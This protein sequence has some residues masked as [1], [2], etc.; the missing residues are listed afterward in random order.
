MKKGPFRDGGGLFFAQNSVVIWYMGNM[1]D[2][3]KAYDAPKRY[4]QTHPRDMQAIGDLFEAIRYEKD[5]AECKLYLAGLN[6][7]LV[8]DDWDVNNKKKIHN[9]IRRANLFLAPRWFHNFMLYTEWVREPEKRFYQPRM[10]ALRPVVEGLQALHDGTYTLLCL[11]LPP[12]VGKSTLAEFFLTFEGGNYPELPN[13][14]SSH[15]SEF[16]HGMY[17]EINRMLDPDGEY[18][19]KDVF[20]KSAVVNTNAKDMRIDLATEKRFETFEFTSIGSGNAGKVRAMN[21]LY[22]DDLVDGIETALSIPRLDK[23]WMQYNTDLRQRKQGDKCKELHIATRWSVH[24]VIGRLQSVYKDDPKAL[25]LSVPALNADDVSNFNYPYGVGFSTQFYHEQREIMDPISWR[26]LYMNE[27]IEREG[28]LYN[29]DELRRF[30]DM[31]T[32]EPDAVLAVC[33]TKDKGTDYYATPIFYQYGEDFYLAD[34]VYDDDLPNHVEPKIAYKLMG[35][36]CKLCQIESN[37]GGGRV[38]QNIDKI[39]RERGGHTTITT[40]FTTRN[41][42]T[43]IFVNAGFIKDHVLFRDKSRYSKEY[44]DFMDAVCSYSH[45]GKNKHD[46]APDSLAMFADMVDSMTGA[47]VEIRKRVGF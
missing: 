5:D 1:S 46:D 26:A 22:C 4:L 23:L 36:K 43:K 11:S 44:K 28:L 19:Y 10:R 45:V 37:S 7:L 29:E 42:E 14:I 20:P 2:K 6:R 38:A 47:R 3:K 15:N 9:L 21:L 16:L 13:L 35:H 24:D 32:E 34:V 27:P 17:S 8:S 18:K 25:F 30:Y 31:P 39:I 40:K 41:K 12:G 33:D